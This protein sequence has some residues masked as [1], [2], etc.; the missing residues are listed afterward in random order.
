MAEPTYIKIDLEPGVIKDDSPLTVGLRLVDCDNIRWVRNGNDAKGRA[1]VVGG[2]ET[3]SNDSVQGVCRGLF[4]WRTGTIPQAAIG[5]TT[6]LQIF[7]DAEIYDA[8]PVTSRGSLTN[9]FTTTLSSTSVSVAHTTHGRAA[10]DRVTFSNASAVGGLTI[11]GEY[12]VTTVTSANAYTITAASAATAAATGGGT[13]YYD[14]YLATGLVSNLGGA[15]YG[16]GGFGVGYY[17]VGSSLTDYFPRTWSMDN[18]V[19]NLLAN[20]RNGA[21]YEARPT[22][23]ASEKLT[24]N[25]FASAGTGWTGGST[26]TFAIGSASATLVSASIS[27]PSISMEANSYGV[28]EVIVSSL[29]TGTAKMFYGATEIATISAAGRTA[30]EF[31]VGDGG[32]TSTFSL[33]GYSATITVTSLSLKQA[34]S[35]CRITAAPSQNTCILVTPELIC[36]ACGTI[37]ADTGLFNAMQIRSSDTGDGSLAALHDWTPSA[38]NLSR[39]W[40][41]SKGSRIVRALNGNGEVLVWT[42]TALYGGTYTTDTNV[43][44]QWRLIAEGCGLIGANAAAVLNGAAFWMT[45]AGEFMAYAG[46]VPRELDCPLARW[47]KGIIAPSQ[48]DKICAQPNTEFGE[49]DWAIPTLANDNEVAIYLKYHPRQNVWANGNRTWTALLDTGAFAIPLATDIGGTLY[50]YEKGT[51]ADGNPLTWSMTT[52]AFDLSEGNNLMDILGFI[53][54]FDSLVGG[55]SV[56]ASAYL[57]PSSTSVDNGPFDVTSMTEKVD[58]R[59][60]GRQCAIT[61]EGNAAPAFMRNGTHRLMVAQSG[62]LR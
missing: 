55:C 59:S 42:D 41:L 19:P 58:F 50:F 40:T 30:A 16:I 2:W 44:Y 52:G 15:G 34:T 56:T 38:Q 54:D 8:T 23:S 35:A 43:V 22:Y 27:Q 49:V 24:N 10:G 3:A 39:R 33:T 17:G 57:Y 36:L 62:S 14:Y 53:P 28:A 11:S 1:Q 31:Y 37:D 25:A 20:P 21:I 48:G 45:P 12:T 32:A 6:H 26:W 46:G 7:Y 61:I 9:P 51:S 60:S 5:T 29:A 47:V 18:F 13:V 4:G